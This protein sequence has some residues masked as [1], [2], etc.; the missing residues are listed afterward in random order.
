MADDPSLRGGPA[1][2]LEPE[3]PNPVPPE[4]V[5]TAEFAAAQQV[6]PDV[7]PAPDSYFEAAGIPELAASVQRFSSASLS[8]SSLGELEIHAELHVYGRAR[9]GRE[10]FLFGR[11]V[12]LAPDGTFD[13]RR[14]LDPESLLLPLL[15]TGVE[16]PTEG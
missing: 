12:P 2:V 16:S 8:S 3:F 5:P 4:R 15:M 11:R 9:P 7:P 10:L 6:E 1:D 14:V 13:I